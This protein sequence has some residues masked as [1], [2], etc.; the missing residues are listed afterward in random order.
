MSRKRPIVID[1]DSIM[2]WLL[3]ALF[4]ILVVLACVYAWMRWVK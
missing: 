3:V 1:V 4:V 2:G